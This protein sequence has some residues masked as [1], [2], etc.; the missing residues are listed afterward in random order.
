MLR[1]V[2][3]HAGQLRHQCGEP[4]D[5]RA[6][7]V[8]ATLAQALGRGRVLAPAADRAAELIDLIRG[9]AKRPGHVAHRTAGTVADHRGGQRGALATVF[10]VDVLDDFFASFVLE[11]DVDVGWFV[12]LPG[13]EPLE[14]HVHPRRVDFGDAQREAHRRIGRRAAALAQDALRSGE[15]D[16]VVDGEEERLVAEFGDQRELPVDQFAGLVRHAVGPAPARALLAEPAQPRGRRVACG[17]QLA[18]VVVTQTAQIEATAFGDAQRFGQQFGWVDRRQR[19]PGAQVALAVRKQ[20]G[21]GR[22]QGGAVT[23]RGQRVVQR[24]PAAHVHVDVARGHRRDVEPP[25]Q[26]QQTG[27]AHRVVGPAMQLHC[28]P[29]TVFEACPQPRAVGRIGRIAGQ[30]QCQQA[31]AVGAVQIGSGQPVT[32]LDGAP[33]PQ[34]DQPAQRAIAGLVLDQQHQFRAVVE[35]DLAADDQC[36]PGL[37]RRLVGAHDAGQRALVG[38]RQRRV[39]DRFRALEQLAGPRR[40]APEAEIA[41]AV[42]LGIGGQGAHANQPCSMNG[43]CSPGAQ[44]TQARWPAAVSTT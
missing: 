35:P 16:D 32:A 22:D 27:L 26:R 43:P 13:D 2:P 4:A 36:Q 21:A 6:V 17:H 28:Q 11:I 42:Q 25:C 1:Q 34:G 39:A 38:D 23:D 29:Q 9:Q 19:L 3:R 30:P 33:S 24:A 37:P 10:A 7:R 12:A 40:P 18:R 14:Q 44:N 41:Q 15:A 8:E 31:G 20:P 5:H